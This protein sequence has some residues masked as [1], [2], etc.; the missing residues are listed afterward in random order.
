MDYSKFNRQLLVLAVLIVIVVFL[1]YTRSFED[2]VPSCDGYITNVYLYLLLG[3][4]ITAFSVLFIAKRRYPI[5]STKSLLFFAIAIIAL[6]ALFM[7]N[8]R[9]ILLNH[10]VWLGFIISLSMGLYTI[11]RYSQYRGILT[12]SLIIVFVLVAGLTT[13]AYAKRDWAE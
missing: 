8:P 9:N 1:V 13:I 4:L 12:S 10:A 2:D 5:T 6:F 7:I 3:L 11:W